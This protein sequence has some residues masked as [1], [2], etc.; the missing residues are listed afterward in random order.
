MGRC[1]E[2]LTR[3]TP[4]ID[5]ILR[6][7]QACQ[8]KKA[9]PTNAI[10]PVV[11]ALPVP[12]IVLVGVENSLDD[13]RRFR[14]AGRIIRYARGDE[15]LETWLTAGIRMITAHPYGE[16]CMLGIVNLHGWTRWIAGTATDAFF[17]STSRVGLPLT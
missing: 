2:A 4:V 12:G 14:P 17:S 10:D 15:F 7:R 9:R 6:K 11:Y 13:S 16:F 5:V 8:L 1:I 3:T